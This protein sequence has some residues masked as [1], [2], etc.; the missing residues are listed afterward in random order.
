MTNIKRIKKKTERERERERER[1]RLIGGGG[2]EQERN[3]EGKEKSDV[4]LFRYLVMARL[5][6][7]P[8]DDTADEEAESAEQLPIASA[9]ILAQTTNHLQERVS[10]I[11]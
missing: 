8:I 11:D 4:Q 5:G 10:S 7:Q 1:K 6:S 3:R 2:I 9:N